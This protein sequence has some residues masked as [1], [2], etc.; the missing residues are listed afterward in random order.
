MRVEEIA[1]TLGFMEIV[2]GNAVYVAGMVH[3]T[4]CCVGFAVAS[5]ANV[6]EVPIDVEAMVCAH[7]VDAIKKKIRSF[8]IPRNAFAYLRY[9]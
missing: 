8:I 5:C 9:L 2:D 7:A 3:W 6:H 4:V 1:D